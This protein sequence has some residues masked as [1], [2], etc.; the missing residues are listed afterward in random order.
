MGPRVQ[1]LLQLT[2]P[3]LLFLLGPGS[4]SRGGGPWAECL[5]RV[6]GRRRLSGK[7]PGPGAMELIPASVSPPVK[8]LEAQPCRRRGPLW[9][10][11]SPA[12]GWEGS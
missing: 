3:F 5:G 7:E 10:S 12:V 2:G 9:A 4:G 11:V 8:R 6:S 1:E